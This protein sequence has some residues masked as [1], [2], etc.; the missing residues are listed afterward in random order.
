MA[1]MPFIP[2][3]RYMDSKDQF[4]T[5]RQIREDVSSTDRKPYPQEHEFNLPR[6][7]ML[8]QLSTPSN[9]K[10]HDTI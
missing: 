9:V 1:K 4:K 6:H 2:D 3:P 5:Q 7:R 8:Q 10:S